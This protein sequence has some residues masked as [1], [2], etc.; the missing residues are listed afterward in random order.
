[1]ADTT[2]L[3]APRRSNAILATLRQNK[4]SWVGLALLAAIV[5]MAVFAPLLAPHDPLQQNIIHRLEPPSAEF[6]LGT[7]S[8]GRDVLSR[9]IYGARISLMVGF[10][11]VA[12]A[13]FVGSTIGILAGYIGG[14][15]D[16][17]VMGIV[18][19]MLAFPTLLLGLMIAAMLGAN[20]ENLIIAI[21]FTEMA[22]FARVAR[23]PTIG[24]KER[25][26]VEAGRAL[27]FGPLRIMGV[28]ILPNMASDVVVMGS[29]WMA[30]AIRM[31]A[32]LS[33]I[34]LGVQPPTPTWGGMIREGFEN[35]LT[36]WWLAIFPSLA[37][38]VTVLALNI[39]GDALR[40]AIDP[41]LR[42]E[43][44]A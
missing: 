27:G 30:S 29:L 2:T 11:A 32:S 14:L 3:S 9:L 42:S 21:A 24:L 43:N 17:I 31:E 40:D 34:G 36:A 12:I 39:L 16:Q 25:D 18:D 37:I 35:I 22:P 26:F 28:H 6:L 4:L 44:A 41:K 5:F 23:A 7:D 1:M 10:V 13:M 20:L 19:V 33:F 38:L 8:F 15:F